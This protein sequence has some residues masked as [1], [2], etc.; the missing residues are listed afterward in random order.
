MIEFE[1]TSSLLDYDDKLFDRVF[2]R[3]L[4]PSHLLLYTDKNCKAHD[5]RH[6][7]TSSP[8]VM[9]SPLATSSIGCCC[10]CARLDLLSFLL[11]CTKQGSFMFSLPFPTET[12]E[13]W[14]S[15][16]LHNRKH[17]HYNNRATSVSLISANWVISWL[18]H[19]I[20]LWNI[21]IIVCCP[22]YGEMYDSANLVIAYYW[23]WG[24]NL[25]C[26]IYVL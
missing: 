24:W 13:P 22:L 19:L 12:C 10:S 2:R 1:A 15:T 11:C 7:A 18:H 16:Y 23:Y 26:I 5:L 3:S 25:S 6:R 4:P 14:L 8:F 20:Y 21:I 9:P 17:Q